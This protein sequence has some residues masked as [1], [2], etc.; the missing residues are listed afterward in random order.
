MSKRHNEKAPDD[1]AEDT[2]RQHYKATLHTLQV[3]LVKLQ[4][5]FIHCDDRILVLLEGRDAAGKDG[6][7]KRIVR[8]L[9]PR[10]TRVVAL[11]RPSDRERSAW[12]FQRYVPHLPAAQEF[13]LFNRSWYN[14]AGVERV[15]GFCTEAEYEEFM[16]TVAD[17]EH[18][19]VRSGIKLLK[20]YLD[21]SKAE[22]KR[23]LKARREDVLKQW[24]TSPIDD[25]AQKHWS[26]YSL[27]R[28]AMLA[29]THNPIAPWTVVRADDKR[30]ARIHLIKDLLTRLHYEG[31]DE[32][33]LMANPDIVF[34][35][36]EIYVRNGMIAA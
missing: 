34:Q 36:D 13:V 28:N 25:Q 16:E 6:V 22:Q 31:K 4:R 9:S 33:A 3:E 7:I 24:K 10:E 12:Y 5:H 21:I 19:L 14:R 17:F 1:G 15:M 35:Y 20:Y 29:R 27:A 26:D 30:A 8:H 32:T 18:M 11:G 2:G 23:R